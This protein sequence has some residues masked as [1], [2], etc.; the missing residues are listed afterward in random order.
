MDGLE[1]LLRFGQPE[2]A[3]CNGFQSKII[4]KKKPAAFISFFPPKDDRGSHLRKY[5]TERS[6]GFGDVFTDDQI[7]RDSFHLDLTRFVKDVFP[8]VSWKFWKIF[9]F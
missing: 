8:L 2:R 9:Q 4:F 3:I 1:G 7:I 5:E 6:I